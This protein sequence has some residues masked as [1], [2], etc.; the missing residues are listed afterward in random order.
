MLTKGVKVQLGDAEDIIDVEEEKVKDEKMQE[1]DV[2]RSTVW[3]QLSKVQKKH[4]FQRMVIPNS[5]SMKDWSIL[6][7][8]YFK[9]RKRVQS[10]L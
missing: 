8:L 7:K 6:V 2:S 10:L 5:F 3:H 9:R 1:H 4:V